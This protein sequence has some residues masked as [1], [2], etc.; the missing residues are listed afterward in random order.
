MDRQARASTLRAVVH[1]KSTLQGPQ[2]PTRRTSRWHSES[3]S[4]SSMLSLQAPRPG[5]LRRA[6][7]GRDAGQFI[8]EMR[9]EQSRAGAQALIVSSEGPAL[10][11][12]LPSWVNQGESGGAP[13]GAQMLHHD[14]TDHVRGSHASGEGR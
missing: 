10:E 2:V 13:H 1:A 5:A 14:H 4:W 12:Y 11:W 6:H 3:R 8:I 9:G 7:P